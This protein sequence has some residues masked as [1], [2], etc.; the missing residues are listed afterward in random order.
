MPDKRA[1]GMQLIG[2]MSWARSSTLV[3]STLALVVCLGCAG[4]VVPV[5]PGPLDEPRASWVV[6]AGDEY[7]AEREVCRSDRDQPCIVPASTDS[8]PISAVVSV[9]LYPAREEETTYRGAIMT[10]FMGNG[11]PKPESKVEYSIKPGQRPYY[12]ASVGRVTSTP[13]EYEFRIALLAE[14]PGETDPH[15]F[16]E[17]I[18]IRVVSQS[19]GAPGE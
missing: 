14:V 8:K 12:I 10:G 16:Q 9:Y 17:A 3:T 5:A 11:E 2:T 18:P 13:G 19:P 7:G 6:R 4:Y 15:Q 1:G